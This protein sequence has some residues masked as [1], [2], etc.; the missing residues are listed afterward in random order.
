M[1]PRRCWPSWRKSSASARRRPGSRQRRSRRR[2]RR[3][4]SRSWRPETPCWGWEAGGARGV[5]ALQSSG[6]GTRTSCSRFV[7][8]PRLSLCPSQLAWESKDLPLLF[9]RSLARLSESDARRAADGQAVRQRHHPQRLSPPLPEPLHPIAVQ[10]DW[11]TVAPD[12][13]CARRISS[14]GIPCKYG[15]P[16]GGVDRIN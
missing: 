13:R 14:F 10:H 9:P 5:P 3:P 15:S 6:G 16:R 7:C 12:S 2:P 8:H 11:P 1:T 4:S